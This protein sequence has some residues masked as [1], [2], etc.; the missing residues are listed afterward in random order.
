MSAKRAAY[1]RSGQG[2]PNRNSNRDSNLIR[3]L[4]NIRDLRRAKTCRDCYRDGRTFAAIY[5]SFYPPHLLTTR[6][7]TLTQ[8]AKQ[9][10]QTTAVFRRKRC[11]ERT[12]RWE[13]RFPVR[14]QQLSK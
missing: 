6:G 2:M 5:K 9:K 7:A 4:V 3:K 8:S 11:E 13:F 1:R 12:A 10:A 14:I